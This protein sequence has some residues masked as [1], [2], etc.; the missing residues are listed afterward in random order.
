MDGFRN[1]NK[2][3]LFIEVL[4]YKRISNTS[5]FFDSVNIKRVLTGL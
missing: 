4:I 1:F 5:P 3:F 2:K